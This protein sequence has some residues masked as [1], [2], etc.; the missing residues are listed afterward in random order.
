MPKSDIVEK[1]ILEADG[2]EVPGIISMDAV[3]SETGVVEIPGTDSIVSVADGVIKIP[4]F[5]MTNKVNRNNGTLKYMQDW[6]FKKQEKNCILK[7]LDGSGQIIQEVDLGSC[8]LS[9]SNI[10]AYDASS[11]VAAQV[12]SMV[13][14]E[15]FDPIV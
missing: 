3:N 1:R 12:Q 5:M 9:S 13:L 11:P 14:P 6:F 10:P 7:R 8:Q 4:T 15:R 2:V